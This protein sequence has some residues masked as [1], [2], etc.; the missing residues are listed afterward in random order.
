[1]SFGGYWV[2]QK[3]VKSLLLIFT[4]IYIY[5]YL[6]EKV[7]IYVKLGSMLVCAHLKYITILFSIKAWYQARSK[8]K[9][10]LQFLI[11]NRNEDFC[12]CSLL[13]SKTWWE[14]I[15][16]FYFFIFFFIFLNIICWNTTHSTY[17]NEQVK[18][19]LN[20]N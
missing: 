14:L 18:G 8:H 17:C 10:P 12:Q 20:Y 11:R 9:Y 15:F 5:I 7:H 6:Y 2:P 19:F 16:V 3:K 4:Y 13:S 1:M